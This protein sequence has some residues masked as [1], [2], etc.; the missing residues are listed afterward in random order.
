MTAGAQEV[1]AYSLVKGVGPR[2][3]VQAVRDGSIAAEVRVPRVQAM[4]A[5]AAHIL[6]QTREQGAQVRWVGGGGY[7]TALNQ[8]HAPPPLLY[9]KGD[10]SLLDGTLVGVVGSREAT[11]Y[12]IRMTRWLGRGLAGHGVT[13]V[14]GLARGVDGA[15]H[16]ACLDAGGATVA[17]LA[18]GVDQV[19]PRRHEKLQGRIAHQ[20]LLVSEFPPG[21][22]AEAHHFPRRN[23]ILAA[24]CA[25]IVVV[26]A[27]ER[28]GALIT[29][30]IA[31]ELGRDVMAVPGPA[32]ARLSKGTNALIRD[33]AQLVMEPDWVAEVVGARAVGFTGSTRENPTFRDPDLNVLWGALEDGPAPVEGLVRR[34]ALPPSR[35]L[36]ALSTLEVEGWVER[37][38]DSCIARSV[39]G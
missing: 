12:G 2:T 13:V 10:A 34:T 20:G 39:S 37:G 30:R 27:A 14:S 15:A 36:A 26:E 21:V 5:Q 29:A 3:V 38:R 28:S 7:P 31:M 22:T 23:R 6:R 8:L 33:G 4:M 18:T 17:V 32:D 25:G 1:L 35:L 16:Q 9:L 11:P 19:Y 24:L